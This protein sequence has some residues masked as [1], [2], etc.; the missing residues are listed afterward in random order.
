M[1]SGL[2]F[3]F[4][5]SNLYG[6][7][8]AL[9]PGHVAEVSSA[10]LA[11]ILAREN[12]PAIVTPELVAEAETRWQHLVADRQARD[13][14][15]LFA[16]IEKLAPLP[17]T[18]L[19]RRAK[20]VPEPWLAQLREGNR[21]VL[22]QEKWQGWIARTDLSLFESHTDEK[23][24]RELLQRYLR[25]RGPVT[26]I[27]VQ[28]DL[29]LPE[30]LVE[31]LLSELHAEKKLVRGEL[32]SGAKIEQWC[33][34][35]NFAELYRRAI[36]QRR[37]AEAPA[38]REIFYRFLLHWHKIARPGQPLA[39][40]MK[41]YRG[42]RLPVHFFEREILRARF[43]SPQLQETNEAFE[44]FDEKIAGGE[45][46][47][48]AERN[49]D[50]SRRYLN[51]Y[52]RGEGSLFSSRAE[53]LAAAQTLSEPTRTV[54]EFLKE[55]GAS[56]LRDI[57]AGTGLGSS[58]VEQ[59]L[60]QLAN[61]GLASCDHYS[62]FIKLLQPAA[63][64]VRTEPLSKDW[65][66]AR[67]AWQTRDRQRRELQALR[68]TIRAR[69][70]LQEGRWF[71]MTSFAVMGKE[72]DE[73]QRAEKQARLLLQRHGIVV[74]DWHRRERGLLPWPKLFQ[75]LKRLEWQGEIR[76]GYFVEGLSGIQFALPEA[77]ESLAQLQSPN[78]APYAAPVF[79]S[80][81]DPALPFGDAVPWDLHDAGGNNIG[82]VRA[83]GNH[84]L[85]AE[86]R[87]VVYSENY[88]TRLWTLPDWRAE[89]VETLVAN[90][91][92][93][94]QLPADLRPRP[95]IEVLRVNEAPAAEC[96]FAETLVQN[97]FECEGES[98][99]L[100]PSKV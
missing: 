26:V 78:N 66:I 79:V 64:P 71:L 7:D 46:I 86:D 34:R 89:F 93:W 42:L 60:S 55:N 95:R 1:A 76:R 11:E 36:A 6:S 98:L 61:L 100:W 67:P 73:T 85:I 49:R 54:F 75:V 23:N 53:L 35:D 14:E 52:L 37:A 57:M 88:G 72:L 24:A 80:T 12:I 48:H 43:A 16:I 62:S 81:A 19:R 50:E 38:S 94:L 47:I 83:A 27:A 90:L 44:N 51:F 4:L 56:F 20:E 58:P 31:R 96:P 3:N 32:V 92:V 29:Q 9:Y 65:P 68:Q 40:L 41:R 63:A 15:E 77:L 25:A 10:L 99:M 22:L 70:S 5:A 59:E 30:E 39:E 33:E 8:R 82:V 13:P 18:E 97:G 2:M 17:E 74:K 91:K 21:I 87:P 69:I 28:Q 84:L 45:V